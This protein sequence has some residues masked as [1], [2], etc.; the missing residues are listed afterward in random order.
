[1][2][3]VDPGRSAR[4]IDATHDV[5]DPFQAA[6]PMLP[7]LGQDCGDRRLS[8]GDDRLEQTPD[9]NKSLTGA[10]ARNVAARNSALFRSNNA[11]WK[12]L[13]AIARKQ[14]ERA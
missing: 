5:V 8:I 9:A 10:L 6:C 4:S 12:K 1:L 11:K 2:L 7:P 14:T 3:S 13:A